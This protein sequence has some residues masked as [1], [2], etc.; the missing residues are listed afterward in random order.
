ML[1]DH[2]SMTQLLASRSDAL[3][4]APHRDPDPD[5]DPDPTYSSEACMPRYMKDRKSFKN[6]D[7]AMK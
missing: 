7:N 1:D 4:I 6:S 3:I 5:P 2:V